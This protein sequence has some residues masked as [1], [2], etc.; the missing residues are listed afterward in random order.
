ML[1]SFTFYI[2]RGIYKIFK[3]K[4]L[5]SDPIGKKLFKEF[6]T[7]SYFFCLNIF[8]RVSNISL[9]KKGLSEVT[10]TMNFKLFFFAVSIIFIKSFSLP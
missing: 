5:I 6:E 3:S 9:S 2:F 4:I 7:K 8:R 1:S 10:W